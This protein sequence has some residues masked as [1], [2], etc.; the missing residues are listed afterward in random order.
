MAARTPSP[1]AL[2]SVPGT[3][4]GLSALPEGL[5]RD[6]PPPNAASPRKIGKDLRRRSEALP[7]TKPQVAADESGYTPGSVRDGSPMPG[8]GMLRITVKSADEAAAMSGMA[9]SRHTSTL[10]RNQD[11]DH[12]RPGVCRPIS[13]SRIGTGQRH[14]D[15]V[16]PADEETWAAQVDEHHR[17]APRNSLRRCLTGLRIRWLDQRRSMPDTPSERASNER[18]DA[19][20]SVISAS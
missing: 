9:P 8:A 1:E 20:E 18:Q 16:P 19:S 15:G 12:R 7:E 14:A 10:A 6:F 11:P 3:F 5:P 17:W 2:P 13:T 4:Q